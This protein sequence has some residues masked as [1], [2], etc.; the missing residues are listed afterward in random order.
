MMICRCI[1]FELSIGSGVAR[2]GAM[3]YIAYSCVLMRSGGWV[4]PALLPGSGF[5]GEGV[6]M[7]SS[8]GGGGGTGTHLETEVVFLVWKGS[9]LFSQSNE[10]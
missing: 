10:I 6:Y 8:I 9:S 2:G 7:Y 5:R 3:G 4:R 1:S